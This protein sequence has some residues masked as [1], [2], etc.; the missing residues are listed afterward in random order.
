M[1]IAAL[2]LTLSF[3][4]LPAMSAKPLARHESSIRDGVAVDS[5]LAEVRQI[6]QA[7]EAGAIRRLD[8]GLGTEDHAEEWLFY[9]DT[10]RRL[11]FALAKRGAVIGSQQEERVYYAKDRTMLARR[12]RWLHDP[13]YAF[14][15]LAP[16]WNPAAWRK[17]ACS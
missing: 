5:G 13:H 8:I 12:V 7:I 10:S 6:Y 15:L 1:M 2:V 11:R 3:A 4:A 9:Y 17:A 14:S 16:V